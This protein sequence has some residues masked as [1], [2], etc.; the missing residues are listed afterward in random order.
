MTIGEFATRAAGGIMMEAT[1][2]VPEGGV[3][4]KEQK[5][6]ALGRLAD[7]PVQVVTLL[8][9]HAGG[10]YRYLGRACRP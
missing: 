10:E 9:T 2:V 3:S 4:F 5:S 7:L 6:V 1:A 8:F